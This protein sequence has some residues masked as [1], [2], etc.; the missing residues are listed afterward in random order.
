M[1]SPV[2]IPRPET[3]MLVD[4]VLQEIGENCPKVLEL[5]CGSGAISLAL[6]TSKTNVSCFYSQYFCR[7]ILEQRVSYMQVLKWIDRKMKQKLLDR[8]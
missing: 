5:C 6:L 1:R 3:E 4:L 8:N 2:F 7:S